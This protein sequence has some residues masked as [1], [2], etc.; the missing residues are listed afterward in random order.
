[1]KP[2]AW[3]TPGAKGM[4]GVLVILASLFLAGCGTLQPPPFVA[5]VTVFQQWPADAAGATYRFAQGDEPQRLEQ[6][7]YQD[8]L[9]VHLARVGLVEAQPWDRNARFTVQYTTRVEPFQT[10]TDVPAPYPY[11]FGP[12]MGWGYGP[13][14]WWGYGMVPFGGAGYQPIPVTAWRYTLQ[15]SIMDR[16][17]NQAEVYQGTVSH[18]GEAGPGDLPF[19]VPYL[20]E[21][22]FTGFP[23]PNGEAS[24]VQV[25][26]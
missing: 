19:M 8:I 1:M 25:R 24:T 3:S 12:Y 5:R 22:L 20:A 23:Q 14:G 7:N 2:F 15:V 10:W 6:R 11:G 26:R 9:R 21:A 4:K 13:P 16:N 18:T 17:R